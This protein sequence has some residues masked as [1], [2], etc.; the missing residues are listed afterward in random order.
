MNLLSEL[1]RR[2]VFRMALLYAITAWLIMQFVEVLM[3]LVNLPVWVGPGILVVLAIGLP[4]AL[5]LSWFYELTPEGIK[6]E[7][8]VPRELSIRHLTDGAWTSSSS[9]YCQRR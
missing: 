4:I 6:Q 7:R 8:D 9:R 3:A 1:K 2:N 5:A